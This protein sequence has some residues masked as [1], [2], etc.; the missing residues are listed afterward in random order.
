MAFEKGK[1]RPEKAGR[2]AGVPNKRTFDAR[3]L[4]ERMGFD[5]LEFLVYTAQENWEALGYKASFL[6]KV[7]LGIEYEEPVITFDD[8]LDAAKTLAKYLYPQLK[9]IEHTG[10]DGTDLFA[11]RLLSAQNRVGTLV[12]D[13][14]EDIEVEAKEVVIDE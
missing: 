4:V 14:R 8:R 5:P 6:T 12:G 11:Q 3:A 2:K 1:P 7:N 10:K 9:S 13:A